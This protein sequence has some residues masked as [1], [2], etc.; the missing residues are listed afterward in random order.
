MLG[1]RVAEMEQRLDGILALLSGKADPVGKDISLPVTPSSLSTELRD[2]PD[3][4]LS[5]L[6]FNGDSDVLNS[7]VP[8]SPG[9]L[10][11]DEPDDIIRKG[12]ISYNK[13][14]NL[15]Q[16]FGTHMP[17]FPYVVI[18]A[19]VSLDSLRREK[20]FLLL[21]IL[22]ISARSNIQLRD[23]LEAELRETLARR[24]VVNCE[25]SLDLVQGLLI[26]LTW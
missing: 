15:L 4:G 22:N 16:A 8:M 18:E 11:F 13:A 25:R 26:Y 9:W 1:R 6:S 20:P 3:R 12:I 14:E 21:S 19:H 23:Q 7:I 17:N 5:Q 10:T 2:Q 24:V